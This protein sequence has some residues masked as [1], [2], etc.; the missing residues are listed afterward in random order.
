MEPLHRHLKQP[1][2]VDADP[3]DTE[4]DAGGDAVS[5]YYLVGWSELCLVEL[6]DAG[7]AVLLLADICKAAVWS[8]LSAFVKH[9]LMD[10]HFRS[11]TALGTS[12]SAFSTLLST[13]IPAS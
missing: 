9:Y 10:L 4:S 12:S 5:D 8:T 13:L 7:R 2:H 3:W 11:H 1:W 6:K